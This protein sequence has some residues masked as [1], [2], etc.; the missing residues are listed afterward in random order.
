[1]VVKATVARRGGDGGDGLTVR[2][3]AMVVVMMGSLMAMARMTEEEAVLA[4]ARGWRRFLA[5]RRGRSVNAHR[6]TT[7]N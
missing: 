6:A 3:V 7:H 5:G 1:M 4:V 2:V